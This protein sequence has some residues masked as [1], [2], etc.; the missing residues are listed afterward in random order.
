MNEHAQHYRLLLASA[1]ASFS[2]VTHNAG[3]SVKHQPFQTTNNHVAVH[4]ESRALTVEKHTKKSAQPLH[5][6]KRVFGIGFA[7]APIRAI[8]SMA[9]RLFRVPVLLP[10]AT[11][12]TWE[13]PSLVLALWLKRLPRCWYG[14]NWGEDMLDFLHTSSPQLWDC[15]EGRP[16]SLDILCSDQMYAPAST[17][18]GEWPWPFVIRECLK[19]PAKLECYAFKG[20]I[21]DT[22]ALAEGG[23]GGLLEAGAWIGLVSPVQFLHLASSS[24]I[25]APGTL[26][27]P[28][29]T[30]LIPQA[31]SEPRPPMGWHRCALTDSHSP[32]LGGVW[33]I[34]KGHWGVNCAVGH[35]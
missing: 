35:T 19:G 30:N 8:Q 20:P 15:V 13:A 31:L 22:W 9:F 26:P 33:Q 2:G 27:R 1:T 6:M 29:Q 32:F 3:M 14:G 17:G 10:Q 11:S 5:L 24:Y 21:P 7:I 4:K 25:W 23:V 18:K 16:R 28:P 34:F 12:L